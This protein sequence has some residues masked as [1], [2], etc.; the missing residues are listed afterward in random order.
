[1]CTVE[2]EGMLQYIVNQL[3]DNNSL[4]LV[5]LTELVSCQCERGVGSDDADACVRVVGTNGRR[6]HH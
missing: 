6:D 5:L 3:H 2:I 4:D 1:M